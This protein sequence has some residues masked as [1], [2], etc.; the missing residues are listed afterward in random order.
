MQERK[1]TKTTDLFTP[2]DVGPLT[3]NNR[4]AMAPLT[5]SRAGSGNVPTQLTALLRP[6]GKR[7]AH[8]LGGD[9]DLA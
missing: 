2:I 5:R 3:L 6:A 9:S 7:R 4:I 1:A 8:H